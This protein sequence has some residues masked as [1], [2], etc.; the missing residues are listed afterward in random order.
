M[1]ITF[2]VAAVTL[3]WALAASV[4][5]AELPR[6]EKKYGTVFCL[7]TSRGK[8]C[9]EDNKRADGI[10]GKYSEVEQVNYGG[11][12]GPVTIYTYKFPGTG[13]VCRVAHHSSG[14][15]IHIGCIGLK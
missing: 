10:L 12:R 5:A 14:D 13:V 8:I 9:L 7:A 2:Q 3:L 1:R 11:G 15:V 4:P 6:L